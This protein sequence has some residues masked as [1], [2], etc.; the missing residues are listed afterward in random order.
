MLK[1]P[2]KEGILP[3]DHLYFNKGMFPALKDI[4]LQQRV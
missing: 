1:L 4:F 3:D 2:I